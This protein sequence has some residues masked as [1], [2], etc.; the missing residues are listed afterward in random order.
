MTTVLLHWN[1]RAWS[2]VPVPKGV[3]IYGL[4]SDGHGGFWVASYTVNKPGVLL[5]GLVMYHYSGGHW[6]RVPAP[7]RPGFV[8]NLTGGN[9]QLIPG[10]WSV[11]ASATLFSSHGI[12]GA[13]LKYGP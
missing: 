6:T 1:G 7:A 12:D 3:N 4:A 10:T 2:K 9:M 8:T 5:A 13:I 11:L